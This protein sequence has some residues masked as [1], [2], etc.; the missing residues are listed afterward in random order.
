MSIPVFTAE[1]SLTVLRRKM[2]TISLS[3]DPDDYWERPPFLSKT[4]RDMADF[5]INIFIAN[6]PSGI[7]LFP[8]IPITLFPIIRN[9]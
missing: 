5:M 4:D 6:M 9:V 8:V 7:D 1:L 2:I 3:S